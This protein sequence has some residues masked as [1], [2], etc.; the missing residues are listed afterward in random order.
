[1]SFFEKISSVATLLLA[2][3]TLLVA[4]NQT[5]LQRQS[6]E[7][8]QADKLPIILP[9]RQYSG[10]N[11]G[12]RD[13]TDH[14]ILLHADL[15]FVEEIRVEHI[16]FLEIEY[17]KVGFSVQNFQVPAL[18]YY[19]ICFDDYEPNESIFYRCYG[20]NNSKYDQNL[21]T[22]LHE[23]YGGFSETP[24]SIRRIGTIFKVT[25]FDQSEIP[26]ITF[27]KVTNFGWTKRGMLEDQ[28]DELKALQSNLDVVKPG[29]SAED[30]IALISKISP[31]ELDW[32]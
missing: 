32:E 14:S 3:A 2:G 31:K 12:I 24:L 18:Y 16:E 28:F 1:M 13:A 19:N 29:S 5:N 17:S 30:M 10:G 23:K 4:V 15:S 25:Y 26:H 7:T 22:K 9:E 27:L 8:E 20:E 21:Q 6:N 11:D